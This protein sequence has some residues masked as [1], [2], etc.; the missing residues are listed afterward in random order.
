MPIYDY[1][2]KDCQKSFE[3][4]LTLREHDKSDIT[5]PK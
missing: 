2:C 5:C 3:L 1:V 4:V